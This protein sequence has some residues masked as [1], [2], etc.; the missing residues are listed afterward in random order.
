MVGEVAAAGVVVAAVADEGDDPMIT[1]RFHLSPSTAMKIHRI[2]AP[3]LFASVALLGAASPVQAAD[4]PANAPAKKGPPTIVQTAY[5]TPE[6]AGRA[7]FEAMKTE[8]LKRIYTILGRGSGKLIYTGDKVAD[9]ETR[10]LFVAAYDKSVKFERHGETS[11]T[12]LIGANDYPFPFPLVKK[13]QGWMFDAHTGAEELVNRRVGENELSAIQTCLAFV[14][15]QR[16]YVLKDRDRNGLLEYAQKIVSTPG[17]QDGL[18]WPTAAGQPP[19]PLGPLAADAAQKGYKEGA[20][21]YHGYKWKIL[22]AQG[23]DAPGGAYDY[24]VDGRMIGGFAFAGWPARWGVS[25][26]MSFICNYE[27]VVYQQNLGRETPAVAEAMKLYNPDPT[28]TK[29]AP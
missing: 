8:N 21:A 16:E 25:G 27:G 26:V 9:G 2:A 7:L 19:S 22:T 4:A 24:I 3:I 11:V 12:M 5:A 14:D 28:W 6:E 23:K 10:D 18:Y 20:N 17:T 15:A 1:R 13:P 29:V